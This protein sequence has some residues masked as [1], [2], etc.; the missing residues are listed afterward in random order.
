MDSEG[1]ADVYVAKREE[2]DGPYVFRSAKVVTFHGSYR[3]YDFLNPT[4][5]FINPTENGDD[6]GWQDEIVHP[7]QVVGRLPVQGQDASFF[8][9]PQLYSGLP[10]KHVVNL[11]ETSVISGAIDEHRIRRA[12]DVAFHLWDTSLTNA[13]R[14]FVRFEKG[15]MIFIFFHI[16]LLDDP[17]KDAT[18]VFAPSS[19]NKLRSALEMRYFGYNDKPANAEIARSSPFVTDAEKISFITLPWHVLSE[20]LLYLDM[21]SRTSARRVASSWKKILT[22]SLASVHIRIDFSTISKEPTTYMDTEIYYVVFLLNRVIKKNIKGLACDNLSHRL[23]GRIMMQLISFI[24]RRKGLKL[25]LILLKN[26]RIAGG[27][28]PETLEDAAASWNEFLHFPVLLPYCRRFVAV[29]W[30]YTHSLFSHIGF[31]GN[32]PTP[33]ACYSIS[34]PVKR[35]YLAVIPLMKFDCSADPQDVVLHFLAMLE[36]HCPPV[37]ECADVKDLFKTVHAGWL[38]TVPYPEGWAGFR[39]MLKAL[40][41]KGFGSTGAFW[42]N[43]DLRDISGIPLNNIVLRWVGSHYL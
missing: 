6:I 42:D 33:P 20:S 18:G 2:E 37:V 12:I 25:S 3:D 43:L 10:F 22:C 15:S 8:Q 21:H 1:I 30:A 14:V 38:S 35:C 39:R 26:C 31:V 40:D 16:F 32:R 41:F 5:V 9:R 36:S 23:E 34:S 13:D 27:V 19:A 29:N 11:D 4:Y 28:I 24:L 7:W 17:I